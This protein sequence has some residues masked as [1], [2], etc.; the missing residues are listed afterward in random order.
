MPKPHHGSLQLENDNWIFHPGKQT[1]N[2][3]ISLPDFEANCQELLETGQLF[4]GHA[5]FWNGY[6]TCNQLSLQQCVLHC[7]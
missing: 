3:G 4:R 2:N 5:K 1:S 6:D 7:V